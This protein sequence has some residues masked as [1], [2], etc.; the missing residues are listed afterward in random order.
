MATAPHRRMTKSEATQ[1]RA[2]INRLHYLEIVHEA[3][4]QYGIAAQDWRTGNGIVL[5]NLAALTYLKTHGAD[6]Y[7]ASKHNR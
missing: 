1:L 7:L 5:S 3:S 6:K 2:A 4:D